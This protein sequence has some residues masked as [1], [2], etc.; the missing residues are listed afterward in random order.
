MILSI[1][2]SL[3][4]TNNTINATG[5]SGT[6]F[7]DV[8]TD[9]WLILAFFKIELW[10]FQD[11]LDFFLKKFE[12]IEKLGYHSN[13]NFECNTERGFK[14]SL[15][16]ALGTSVYYENPISLRSWKWTGQSSSA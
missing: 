14:E 8:D 5:K 2:Y 13:F 15:Y 1:T 9:N 3:L 11:K 6:T 7:S 10:N 4:Q 12:K 16:L